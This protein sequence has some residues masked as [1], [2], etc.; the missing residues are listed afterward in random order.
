MISV[1]LQRSAWTEPPNPRAVC[2]WKLRIRSAFTEEYTDL[3]ETMTTQILS[4][5]L[6]P[7]VKAGVQR[8]SSEP[9]GVFH[10]RE[11]YTHLGETTARLFYTLAMDEHQRTDD[12]W[13]FL[14]GIADELSNSLEV[15][16]EDGRR[17]V[18]R[19]L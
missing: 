14:K 1:A 3:R 8:L 12:D 2:A 15:A 16:T 9:Q 6:T 10:E 11:F 18:F 5:K 4:I 7:H 17:V 19:F 13:E